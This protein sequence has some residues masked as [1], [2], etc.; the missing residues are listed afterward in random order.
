MGLELLAA[1]FVWLISMKEV[2]IVDI[3]PSIVA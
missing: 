2:S 3:S 1:L